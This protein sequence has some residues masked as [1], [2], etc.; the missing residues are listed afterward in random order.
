MFHIHKWETKRNTGKY[1]YQ[2][3]VKCGKRRVMESTAYFGYQPIDSGWI[4]GIDYSHWTEMAMCNECNAV[5]DDCNRHMVCEKC[6]ALIRTRTPF[7][8]ILRSGM[9]YV[10]ARKI[11][12]VWEVRK[13]NTEG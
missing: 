6:G 5:F 12:G 2:E 4:K 7:G 10:S 1:H 3:C 9:E 11:D 8:N 13:N